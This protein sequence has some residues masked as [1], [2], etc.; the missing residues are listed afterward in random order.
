MASG[1]H[2]NTLFQQ[3]DRFKATWRHPRFKDW[4]L[5]DY[6]LTRQRDK[7]GV[8]HT[9]LVPSADCYT[10]HRLVR[11]KVTFAFKCPPKRKGPQTQKLQVHTPRDPRVK[12]NLQVMFE[13]GL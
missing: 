13:E 2:H 10:D 6:V 3:N 8:P 11:C 7:R 4:L 5:L 1:R 9:R 12:N